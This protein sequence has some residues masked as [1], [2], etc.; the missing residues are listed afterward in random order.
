MQAVR[1][2]YTV[3][4]E[5]TATNQANIAA[6]MAELR[7]RAHPG[8]RYA[9]YLLPDGQTFLH[10]AMFADQEARAVLGELASFA[11]FQTELKASG[12]VSPP[13]AQP[14]ELVGSSWEIF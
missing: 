6:V 5:Y 4:P 2:Q 13:D 10:V 1:V 14:L 9:A 7:E 3:R 8:V 12:L 11:T